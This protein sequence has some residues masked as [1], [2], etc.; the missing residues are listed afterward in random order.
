[1]MLS[2]F[3]R[4]VSSFSIHGCNAAGV[5]CVRA[6]VALTMGLAFAAAACN[7]RRL[8][9]TATSAVAPSAPSGAS[10][11]APPST[12]HSGSSS[13]SA[14]GGFERVVEF[15]YATR[16]VGFDNSVLLVADAQ[17]SV[18]IGVIDDGSLRFAPE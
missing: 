10:S 5:R 11:I 6:R 16:L 3:D 1:M 13:A 9:A 7:A 17:S 14:A 18:P 2:Y 15:Y 12:A 4:L 8:D